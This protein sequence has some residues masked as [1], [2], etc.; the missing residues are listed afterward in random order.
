MSRRNA[1]YDAYYLTCCT[2]RYKGD[3]CIEPCSLGHDAAADTGDVPGHRLALRLDAETGGAL[4]Q[5]RDAQIRNKAGHA[6]SPLPA[7]MK[8]HCAMSYS[9]STVMRYDHRSVLR[10]PDRLIS[11]WTCQ[12]TAL[13]YS[14]GLRTKHA[15]SVAFMLILARV[16]VTASSRGGSHVGARNTAAWL[17]RP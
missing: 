2:S 6:A 14:T 4:P 13:V 10:W 5:R 17:P 11:A 15:E 12:R 8:L 7:R 9:H 1:T 16:A 3:A